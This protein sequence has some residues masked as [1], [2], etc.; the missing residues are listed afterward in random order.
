MAP[1]LIISHTRMETRAMAHPPVSCTS[2]AAPSA[3]CSNGSPRSRSAPRCRA[4]AR[5]PR[6]RPACCSCSRAATGGRRASWP[7]RWNLGALGPLRPGAAHGGAGLGSGALPQPG[8][9]PARCSCGCCPPAEAQLARPAHRH[10]AKR[11]NQ[12]LTAGFTTPSSAPVARWLEHVQTLGDP[13]TDTPPPRRAAPSPRLRRWTLPAP[14]A[15]ACAATF[16]RGP[17]WPRGR[18]RYS[19]HRPTG[20]APAVLL[21]LRRLAGATG[22]ARAGVRLPGHRPSL[23]GPLARCDAPAVDWGQ[24]D[25]VGGAAVAAR[26]AAQAAQAI[27]VGHSAGGQ[28]LG[29]LPN[30]AQ[31]GAPGG[32]GGLQRLVWR[33]APGFRA[34][35]PAGPARR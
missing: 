3:A 8:T 26:R 2:W 29:L 27:L 9:T 33:H 34:Q 6:R 20:R 25:Q 10:A 16:P 7:R 13:H 35:G 32:R 18:C 28:M 22:Y 31:V 14:T 15:Y 21:A 19:C 1:G 30:H 24:R 4:R 11:T 17:G 12:R 5:P 23:H